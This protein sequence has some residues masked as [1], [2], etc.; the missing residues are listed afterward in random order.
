MNLSSAH[1]LNNDTS[2]DFS[3][4]DYSPGGMVMP[5]RS[6]TYQNY[7]YSFNGKEDDNDVEGVSS[8]WQDYGLR[9]YNRRLARFISIDPLSRSFPWYTPYQFAGN[10][11]IV[12][13]DLDGAE[14]ILVQKKYEPFITKLVAFSFATDEGRDVHTILKA[15][16]KY[17]IYFYTYDSRVTLPGSGEISESVFHDKEGFVTSNGFIPEATT[18]SF[19]DRES[20]ENARTNGSSGSKYRLSF[21]ESQ[22]LDNTFS[23]GKGIILI[24]IAEPIIAYRKDYVM[25]MVNGNDNISQEMYLNAIESGSE[26]I[27]HEHSSHGKNILLGKEVSMIE[28]HEKYSGDKSRETSYSFKDLLHNPRYKNTTAGK[29]ARQ[30]KK[31]VENNMKTK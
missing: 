3:L 22:D 7:Q 2:K 29:S 11:P 19:M 25:D 16:D 1:L 6:F 21:I 15:Q 9:I 4:K 30:L 14:E 31:I 5:E 10:K 17:D 24:G 27:L 18:T 26:V 8:G 23:Q 20:F 13:I 12:A 28:E